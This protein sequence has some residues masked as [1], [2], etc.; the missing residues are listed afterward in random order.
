VPGTPALN[1]TT[2][3]NGSVAL[4]WSPPASNGGMTITGYRIFRGT[5][6]GGAT[7]L[8][9]VGN[10]T[11]WT[12]TSVTNGMTYY[13]QVSA[14]NA[15]GASSRSTEKS[16]TPVDGTGKVP[17]APQSLGVKP[18]LA[19]GIGL[20][21]KAPKTV[22]SSPVVAYR[23]YRSTVSK[24][25]VYLATVG[26]V[27]AFTDTNVQNGTTYYYQVSAVNGAGESPRTAEKAAARGTAPTAPRSLTATTASGGIT[28]K[29]SAPSATGGAALIAYRIYR[30]TSSGG[31][32]FLVS[33]SNKTTS[34]VDKTTTKGVRYYYFVRA[35]NDLGESPPSNEVNALG[36]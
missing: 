18:N 20:T 2:G 19:T 28:L 6:S 4:G 24:G 14:V 25:A 5:S 26:N 15:M 9:N 33:V 32:A 11:A 29:W 31:Q 30:S 36:G 12:D 23:I 35:V 3:N 21:W 22:G 10:I 27:L 16:A 17:T 13:Y 34:Y 7:M 1:N 8:T